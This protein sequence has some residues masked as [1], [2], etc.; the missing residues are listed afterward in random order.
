VTAHKGSLWMRL[1]TRGKSA[2]GSQPEL[3]RNAV[4][5]MAQV[6]DALETSY[7]SQLRRRRHPLL[8]SATVSVGAISGGTQANI[9]PD[10]CSIIVDRRTLPGETEAGVQR[11]I[12]ALLSSRRLK[13][14]F[15]SEKLAPCLPMETAPNLPLVAR[16]L[17]HLGQRRA[18]GVNYFCDA[19][20][21]AHA[22]IPSVVF[23]PGD[24]A[25]AH[26]ADEWISLASLEKGTVLMRGF[27]QSLS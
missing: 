23:G 10:H 8:G 4:H 25:Q 20:V 13:V 22:G 21:L 27:L 6:V 17:A 12:A 2:H 7:A 16:F 11:E 19:S 26:T 1:E 14:V 3:G 15:G 5:A 9:V 18:I 24:I